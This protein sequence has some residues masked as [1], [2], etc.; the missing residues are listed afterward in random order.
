MVAGTKAP[1]GT[2]YA[3]FRVPT[4]VLT[5]DGTLLVCAEARIGSCQDQAPKD[6]ACRRSADGGLTWTP[7]QLAVGPT[8]HQPNATAA[9]PDFTARTPYATVLP[10]GTVL[11]GWVNSTDPVACVNFQQASHDSGATWSAPS[12][13]DFGRWEGVLL[14]PGTGIVLGGASTSATSATSASALPASQTQ[15][16]EKRKSAHE[17]RV[18]A[19]GATGYVGGMPMA[20]AVYYSDDGGATYTEAGGAAPFAQLQECQLAE[21]S[22]G[23]VMANARNAHLNASC[24]C[25]AVAISADGGE[26][27]E[28]FTFD[29]ALVEPVCSAGLLS[30]PGG[31]LYVIA[32][33]PLYFLHCA[34]FNIEY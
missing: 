4:A 21:L 34:L 9:A 16:G 33:A 25:R 24:D 15:R 14:G 1:W 32:G 20:M 30:V 23:R 7:L 31:S 27:W 2:T 6:V 29:P 12:H 13:V 17:G 22:D 26:T 8:S 18:L 10:N 28:P 3:C 11:L 19:C 5:A